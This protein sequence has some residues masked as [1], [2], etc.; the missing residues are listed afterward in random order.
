MSRINNLIQL[1]IVASLQFFHHD[2]LR[3]AFVLAI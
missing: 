1:N 3:T 2:Y